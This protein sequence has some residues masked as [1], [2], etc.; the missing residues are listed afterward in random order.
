MNSLTTWLAL[1][2][3]DPSREPP[4]YDFFTIGNRRDQSSSVSRHQR[5]FAKGDVCAW[6]QQRCG[7]LSCACVQPFQ[8]G[9]GVRGLHEARGQGCVVGVFEGV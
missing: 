2:S 4:V 9:G 1:V 8:V 3:L 7:R 6:T 5:C